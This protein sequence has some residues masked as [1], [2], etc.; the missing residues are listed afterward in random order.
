MP[1]FTRNAIKSS[2]L[3]LLEDRPLHQITIKDIVEDCGVNRNSF[4]YHFKDMPALLEEIIEETIQK[5]VDTSPTE[6]SFEKSILV[7]LQ[8]ISQNKRVVYHIYNSVDHSI[9]EHYLLKIC[10]EIVSTYLDTVLKGTSISEENRNVLL[11]YHQCECFGQIIKW[12]NSSMKEDIFDEVHH[13]C[14]L[15]RSVNQQFIT[16]DKT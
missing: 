10:D 6:D 2:F 3:K 14:E 11:H 12:L 9:L 8:S 16:K 4:Y 1:N 7:I 13:F 15:S 5:A